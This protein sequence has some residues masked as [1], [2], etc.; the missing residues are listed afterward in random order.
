M[1]NMI[2]KFFVG[3]MQSAI[4]T[5]HQTFLAPIA[6]PELHLH[7]IFPQLCALNQPNKRLAAPLKLPSSGQ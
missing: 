5:L 4:T 1:M 2:G 7:S 6:S 3:E